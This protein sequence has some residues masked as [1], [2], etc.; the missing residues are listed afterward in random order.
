[1]FQSTA[2]FQKDEIIF[3]L[4]LHNVLFFTIRN[5]KIMDLFQVEIIAFKGYIFFGKLNNT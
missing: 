2:K 4:I 3:F 1:M 5:L